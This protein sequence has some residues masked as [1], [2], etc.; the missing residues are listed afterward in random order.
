MA[1]GNHELYMRR[2][3]EQSIEVQQMR[4][5]E[6]Q[7][8]KVRQ[9]KNEKRIYREYLNFE[10]KEEKNKKQKNKSRISS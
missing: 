4:Y 1:A 8:Q 5:F 10:I 7:Q 6:E 3:R 9:T 2:R